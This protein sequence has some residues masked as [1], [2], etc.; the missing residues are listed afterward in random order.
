MIMLFIFQYYHE[1][2]CRQCHS[3]PTE[4]SICLLCGEIVCLKQNCCKQNNVCEAVE[5]HIIFLNDVFE[6][7][8]V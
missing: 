1:R 5:V 7:P 8:L 6:D 2:Q 3:V 4:I